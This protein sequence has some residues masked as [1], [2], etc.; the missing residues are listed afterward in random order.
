MFHQLTPRT[1]SRAVVACLAVV[2]LASFGCASKQRRDQLES[3]ARDWCMTIRASQVI[4]VYPLTQ[5][6][7]PGD[8]FLVQLPI[9]KQQQQ[10]QQRGFLPLDNHLARL[11]VTAYADFYD[12][13]FLSRLQGTRAKLPADWMRPTSRSTA[14]WSMAPGAAFPT[15]AFSV[16][17]SAGLSLA[18]PIS[19]VPVGLSLLGAESAYGT[20]TIDDARTLGVDIMSLHEQLQQW[21]EQSPD[22]RDFL[23]AYGAPA[24]Q[25]PRNFLRVVTRIYLTGKLQVSLHDAST[26]AA[27]ADAGLARPIA[28]M[29]AQTPGTATETADIADKNYENVMKRLNDLLKDSQPA[30]GDSLVPG[31]SVRIGAASA[32]SIA[33]SETFDPPLVIGYLGFDVPIQENGT[34]GA[35]IPTHALISGSITPPTGPQ[36]TLR[37]IAEPTIVKAML[38]AISRDQS[39]SAMLIRQELDSLVRFI[40]G[41]TLAIRVEDADPAPDG[42]PRLII[43][44]TSFRAINVDSYLS[45][46]A[47]RDA[48][49]RLLESGDGVQ[50]MTALADTPT[51]ASDQDIQQALA[52]LEETADERRAFR[53]ARASLTEYYVRSTP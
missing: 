17:S 9:D 34:L 53:F 25:P 41:P 52:R 27:G 42:T 37:S 29:L 36:A 19:G 43:K 16:N 39:H 22:R 48:Y 6:L 31:G 21:V 3:V 23:A 12:A 8:V 24:S 32:R 4:P 1:V 40:P 51:L 44:P 10:Y 15:Y 35:P 20:V 2:M 5:D 38:D 28:S 50:V 30:L 49:R 33:M 18:I 13:S 11:D 7:Q 45:Y 47:N 46:R 26:R 14:P